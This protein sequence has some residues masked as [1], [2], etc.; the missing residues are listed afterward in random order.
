MGYRLRLALFCPVVVIFLQLQATNANN[1]NIELNS[2]QPMSEYDDS[3]VVWDTLRLKKKTRTELGLTGDVN[4]KQ[5]L[6]NEQQVSLQIYKYDREN[7]RRGP[8][9]FQTQ[10]PFCK[11]AE[12][13][14][15]TYDGM[16]KASNLPEK[17]ECPFPKN[18]YTYKD[19]VLD[20][21]ALVKDVPNGDYLI[22][23]VLKHNGK[24]VSGIELDVTVEN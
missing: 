15:S 5:N 24:A 8:I 13:L 17:F 9:V 22:V 7:K 20:T 4:I 6:G 18:T 16:V 3:W 14:K 21:D 1:R 19:Y 12:S 23:A 11:L 10:K 2:F